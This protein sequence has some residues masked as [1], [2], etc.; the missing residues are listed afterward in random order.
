[1]RLASRSMSTGA[2]GG[3]DVVLLRWN[4]V[5]G[6]GDDDDGS[7]DFRHRRP[8]HGRPVG[9]PG[10]RADHVAIVELHARADAMGLYRRRPDVDWRGGAVARRET[11]PL[12]DSAGL[13]GIVR[14]Q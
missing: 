2:E 4:A 8:S 6:R 9:R 1:M 13:S 3:A 14:R 10:P 5:G 11:Q 12:T 7:Q